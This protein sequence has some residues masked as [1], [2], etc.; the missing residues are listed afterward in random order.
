MD[1]QFA[2]ALNAA[3]TLGIRDL[4]AQVGANRDDD[5]IVDGDRERSA[6]VDGVSGLGGVRGNTILEDDTDTGT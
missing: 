2:L 4:S 6:E 3:G 1:A 5:F